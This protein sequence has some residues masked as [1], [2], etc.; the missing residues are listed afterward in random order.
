MSGPILNYGIPGRI[1]IVQS[2]KGSYAREALLNGLVFEQQGIAN[3]Y[4]FGFM[5]QAT[6]I[7]AQAE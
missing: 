7:P 3:P 6:R 1:A 5:V 2:A 4:A